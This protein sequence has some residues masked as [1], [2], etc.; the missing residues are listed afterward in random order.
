MKDTPHR[1]RVCVWVRAHTLV[2]E[3]NDT[4]IAEL[5]LSLLPVLI[6]QDLKICVCVCV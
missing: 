3:R 2:M 6:G 5:F 1:V 4:V